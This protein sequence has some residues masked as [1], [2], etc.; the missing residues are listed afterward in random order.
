[1]NSTINLNIFLFD[2]LSCICTETLRCCNTKKF[3]SRY[4]EL[5]WNLDLAPFHRKWQV[6]K[7]P[8]Q[9]IDYGFLPRRLAQQSTRNT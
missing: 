5:I 7:T 2:A 4:A 8:V 3:F 1:M 6:S 9:L